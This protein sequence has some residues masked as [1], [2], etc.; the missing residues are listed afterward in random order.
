MTLGDV[1]IITS[2]SPLIIYRLVGG[3]LDRTGRSA[4]SAKESCKKYANIMEYNQEV[5]DLR[6]PCIFSGLTGMDYS[7]GIGTSAP[8]RFVAWKRTRALRKEKPSMTMKWNPLT[9]II[10]ELFSEI[11]CLFDQRLGACEG[12]CCFCQ[13][14]SAGHFFFCSSQVAVTCTQQSY[15]TKS[16]A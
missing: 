11:Y 10:L 8:Q 12:Y 6:R 5:E 2:L 16:F 15:S 14:P 7:L 3:I 13:L 4:T 9:G 1:R